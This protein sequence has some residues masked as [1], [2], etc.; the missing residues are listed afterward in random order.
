MSSD[1]DRDVI[2]SWINKYYRYCYRHCYRYTTFR[3]VKQQTD[4]NG[5]VIQN[6]DTGVDET[7]FV[8]NWNGA[9]VETYW[10]PSTQT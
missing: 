7:A 3:Q 6:G 1:N 9:T 8:R 10:L 5:D 4:D 2:S